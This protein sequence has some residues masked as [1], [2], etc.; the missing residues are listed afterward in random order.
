MRKEKLKIALLIDSYFIPN[1]QYSI[2]K[3]I[4]YSSYAEIKLII[5]KDVPHWNRSTTNSKLFQWHLKFDELLLGR[6]TDCSRMVDSGKILSDNNEMK[7]VP[8]EDCCAISFTSDDV[9]AIRKY[10]CDVILNIG[11]GIVKGDILNAAKYGVWAYQYGSHPHFKDEAFG[12]WEVMKGYET[13]VSTLRQMDNNNEEGKVIH[14]SWMPTHSLSVSKTRNAAYW[15]ASTFI[16][17]ILEGLYIYGDAYLERLANNFKENTAPDTERP[18]K[19]PSIQTTLKNIFIHFNKISRRVYQKVVSIDQWYLLFKIKSNSTFSTSTE[20]FKAL[21]PP[22]D[23]FWADPF[24]ISQDNRHYIFLEEL[25]FKTKKGHISVIELDEQGNVL[26]SGKALERPYHLSYPFVFKYNE[27]YYM[28]PETGENKTI[29]LYKCVSFPYKWEFVMNLM[30]GFHTADATL[31]YHANKWW[32]FC[33]ID[34]TGREVGML[35]EL[36]LFFSDDLFTKNWQPH[37]CN[38][39]D[40]N[41]KTAR[42]AGNIFIHENKIY[43]PSQDCSGSYGKA[44]NFN[45]I[46]RLSETE[47]EE[48][49]VSK[50]VPGWEKNIKRSHTFNFNDQITV[51]DGLK[52]RRRISL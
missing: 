37:P 17:R 49:V 22:T 40:T 12:Y 13:T 51:M 34:S 6:E 18:Y 42:P 46:I 26:Q 5:K 44:I 28:L 2:I 29:E 25:L 47:Y 39:I 45:Q 4:R 33:C 24:V 32:L 7:V 36:H 3:E 43:R 31:F 20:N 19:I 41:T 11:F 52:C 38:P 21:T 8:V 27:H 10:K 48:E 1:W 23:R 35:D 9:Q 16:P 30:E 50:I 14:R 15:R